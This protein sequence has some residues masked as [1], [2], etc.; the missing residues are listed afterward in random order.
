MTDYA[1]D[2]VLLMW[3]WSL[4]GMQWRGGG[5]SQ[6]KKKDPITSKG[7]NEELYG[8]KI[9]CTIQSSSYKGDLSIN[10]YTIIKK[11]HS[12]LSSFLF[13]FFFANKIFFLKK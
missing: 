5:D 11:K 8:V 3:S 10:F 1:L 2:E 12:F 4:L 6:T 7:L 9:S 13:F